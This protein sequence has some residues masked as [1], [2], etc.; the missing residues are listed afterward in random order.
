[1]FD[2]SIFREIFESKAVRTVMRGKQQWFVAEDM[3]VLLGIKD[4]AKVI[5]QLD[6]DERTVD[7]IASVEVAVISEPGVYHLILFC[8]QDA[9][10][11]TLAARFSKFFF[12]GVLPSLVRSGH[13]A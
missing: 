7:L 2:T 11:G 1:M 6:D 9:P 3:C 13:Y 4:W 10:E 8:G 5:C 12:T